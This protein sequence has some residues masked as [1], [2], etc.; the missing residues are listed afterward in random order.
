MRERAAVRAGGHANDC[1]AA[2]PRTNV[3]HAVRPRYAMHCERDGQHAGGEVRRLTR[4]ADSLCPIWCPVCSPIGYP[5]K[6]NRM[7]VV[8]ITGN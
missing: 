2:V 5:I 3:R 6:Y 8:Q 1:A 4:I 7:C